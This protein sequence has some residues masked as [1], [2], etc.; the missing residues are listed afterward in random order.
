MSASASQI[1]SLTIVYST[2]YSR[3]R[4]KK[5]P[6]LRV[7]GN[8]EGNSPVTGE[9]PAQRA[10]YAENVS[11]WWRHY[12][13]GY[14]NY[15]VVLCNPIVWLPGNT[16]GYTS[17]S[18]HLS[19]GRGFYRLCWPCLSLQWRHN[20]HDGVSNHRRL[21]CLLNFFSGAY[22]REHQNSTPLAFV[23]GIHRWPDILNEWYSFYC[24]IIFHVPRNYCCHEV[25]R[26]FFIFSSIMLY[27]FQ[28]ALS[29]HLC[30]EILFSF[31]FS[32]WSNSW[33]DLI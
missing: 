3:R 29:Y 27:D 14:A 1:T 18:S 24:R 15:S 17:T 20:E 25:Q 30:N 19:Q 9:F 31:V 22:Q 8:C 11:I 12:G 23:R 33:H 6:K 16:P 28:H 26:V 4:S 7:T 21:D 10:S 32:K 2:V 13:K 5:T